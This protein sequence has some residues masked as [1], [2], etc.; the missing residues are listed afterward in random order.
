MVEDDTRLVLGE[1]NSS[2]ITYELEPG[3]YNFKDLSQALFNLLQPEYEQ[4]NN[5]VFIDFA[6]ITKKTILVV[7]PCIIV[8]RFDE[9]SFFKFF[10]G[11]KTYWD[12][13]HYKEYI[14]QKIVNLN[15]T[16]KI[17]LKCDVFDGCIVS[18]LRQ[19]IILLLF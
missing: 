13:K 1:Y 16:N 12:Y 14:S 18:R 11:F 17:H 6:D 15:T 3:I 8:M 10:L 9:K 4:F 19:P 7:S 2:F 5:T